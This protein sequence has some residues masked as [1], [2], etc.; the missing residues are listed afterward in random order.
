VGSAEVR[1]VALINAR[2]FCL[3]RYGDAG[4]KRVLGELPPEDVKVLEGVGQLGW[5]E[6]GIYDR[7]H[8][9]I[10][11]VLGSGDHRTMIELGRYS[12]EHDLTV[13]MRLF[14]RVASPQFLLKRH[15][16]LW[17]RYQSSGAWTVESEAARRVRLSLTGW[18]S[19][20]EATCV[21]LASYMERFL[22]IVGA[23]RARITR[24][25]CCSRGDLACEYLIEWDAEP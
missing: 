15:V 6:V 1:G 23:H 2:R 12:A 11:R 8:E 20:S 10:D 13:T 5:Y 22:Q 21:R 18:A 9:S 19:R 3:D 17:R 25:K 16:D 4:W 7:L 24:T 14:M